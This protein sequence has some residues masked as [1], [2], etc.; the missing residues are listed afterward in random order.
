VAKVLVRR[1][2]KKWRSMTVLFGRYQ[3]IG[4][5]MGLPVW[6]RDWDAEAAFG[7]CVRVWGEVWW[8]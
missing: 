1:Q 3:G 7:D 8:G 4:G 5:G 6:P 2:S